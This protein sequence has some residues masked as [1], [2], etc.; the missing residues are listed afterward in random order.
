MLLAID[1]GNTQTVVGLYATDGDRD[2]V[3][4]WRIATN[5][6]RT[7]DEHALVVQEFLGF[8]GFS[9]DD[10]VDGLAVASSVPD[11][12]A[13][14]RE[15][16]ERYFG[17]QPVVV[18]PGIKTG[19]A[20][21]YDNPKEVG[22]DRMADAVGAFDLY[23]GPTI[24]VDFG[25]ATTFEAI[26][27]G[28]EYLGG[29]IVPGIEIS[30]DALSARAAAL[31]RIELVAPRSVIGKSTIESMQS[32]VVYG[33]TAQVD[34]LCE[35][36]V[37]ELGECTVVATGGLAELIAPLSG[38]IHHHEPLLTLHGLR[39]IWEMNVPGKA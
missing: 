15:M 31:G 9:W 17:F 34:G 38:A 39:L 27:E 19:L 26:S 21:R 1:A 3:D 37:A 29:A 14:L 12:T 20:V 35:R 25:T 22:A 11:V 32:G 30:L 2:L 8:H 23:G 6:E 5:A 24:V 36:M 10:D 33:F 7:A 16:S 13:A 4:H 28:G 18:E